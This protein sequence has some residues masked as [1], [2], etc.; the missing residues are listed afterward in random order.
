MQ[1]TGLVQKQYVIIENCREE[2]C[3]VAG[4]YID[5]SQGNLSWSWSCWHSQSSHHKR[6]VCIPGSWN[7]KNSEAPVLDM[8]PAH[9]PDDMDSYPLKKQKQKD[10]TDH[11]SCVPIFKATFSVLGSVSVFGIPHLK[12]LWLWETQQSLCLINLS[13]NN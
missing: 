4:T 6:I 8:A 1:I 11:K 9:P 13:C 3:F 7:Q 2:K 5:I 10:G 12:Y